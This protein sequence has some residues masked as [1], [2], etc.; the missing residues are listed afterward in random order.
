MMSQAKQ[1]GRLVHLQRENQP[2]AN[3][4]TAWL[5]S[6]TSSPRQNPV[7]KQA[8]APPPLGSTQK[9]SWARCWQ[10]YEGTGFVCK[11]CLCKATLHLGMEASPE[12]LKALR[13]VSRWM[14]GPSPAH[15][16]NGVCIFACGTLIFMYLCAASPGST[17]TSSNGNFSLVKVTDLFH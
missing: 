4:S 10:Y 14:Q 12:D 17:Q 3:Q 15:V 7:G 6:R 8:L 5:P 16:A 13:L 11:P 1:R 2:P 9:L